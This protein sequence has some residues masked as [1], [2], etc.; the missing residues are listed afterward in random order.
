MYANAFPL[1]VG[2]SVE[3]LVIE[4]D[5]LVENASA[6]VQFER[7]PALGEVQLYHVRPAGQAAADVGLRLRGQVFEKLPLRITGDAVRRIQQ[8]QRGRG[9]HRLLHR[10]VRVPLR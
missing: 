5:E 3:D 6:R 9:D 1:S 8:A 10:N 2:E 7:E 4:R